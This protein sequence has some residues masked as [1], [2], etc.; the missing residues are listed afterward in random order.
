MLTTNIELAKQA[1]MAGSIIAIPTETVYGL[2]GNAFS[3][4]AVHK[5]FALKKRPLYNPL[6]VHIRS[7]DYLSR[8]A[9]D[10]PPAAITLANAFWPGP[11]TLILKK[12]PHIPALVTAG[13]DTVAVRVP[14]HPLTL[15]L[16]QQLDFP[17]AAPSANP[18]GSVSP[19]TAAHVAG[20]F[21]EELPIILDGG[22]CQKGVESTII[23]FENDQPVL[24]RLGAISV[25][26]IEAV[27]G[28]LLF[29]TKGEGEEVAAPGMLSRHYSPNTTTLLTSDIQGMLN[30]YQGKRVGLLLFSTAIAGNA[31]IHQEI[32]SP[33]GDLNEAAS[34]LYAALHRLDKLNLDVI[35]AERFPDKGLGMTINDRLRR[36]VN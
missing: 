24:Y 27:S 2:A 20:Y 25:E 31:I 1:L 4:E 36:A 11:L 12:Q 14:D 32:L 30:R 19:T 3:E 7:V 17:L 26:R 15:S 6:I 29:H 21:N 9:M 13:K 5:I 8:V 28:N 18:F 34:H 23:G 16:L 35:I 10:I 33:S 22:P